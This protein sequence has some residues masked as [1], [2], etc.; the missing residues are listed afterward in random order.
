MKWPLAVALPS[1]LTG[2]PKQW[3]IWAIMQ[4]KLGIKEAM[5]T[6]RTTQHFIHWYELAE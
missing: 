2:S 3:T 5:L 4:L 1:S 6:R